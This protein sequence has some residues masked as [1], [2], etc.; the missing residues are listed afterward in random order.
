MGE[1]AA[2][3]SYSPRFPPLQS[4]PTPPTCPLA[5]AVTQYEC[6]LWPDDKSSVKRLAAP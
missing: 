1:G 2:A 5:I 3:A 6:P 4:P